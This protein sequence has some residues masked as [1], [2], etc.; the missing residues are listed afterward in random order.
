MGRG[1]GIILGLLG[2]LLPGYLLYVTWDFLGMTITG[3]L[4]Q[5]FFYGFNLARN[6]SGTTETTLRWI[7]EDPIQFWKPEY[8][9]DPGNL[10]LYLYLAGFA[11]A[12]LG[13]ILMLGGGA[14]GGAYLFLLAGLVNLGL[15]IV[16][17]NNL[18]AVFQLP[19]ISG[20]PIPVG[21][22]FLILAGLVG[23]NE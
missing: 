22:I 14:K 2:V 11:L 19:N 23:R 16:I 10:E 13:L 9:G 15:M 20:Y 4:C 8:W 6:P 21:S 17:Y 18:E 12:V 5:G 3:F 1:S 7:H